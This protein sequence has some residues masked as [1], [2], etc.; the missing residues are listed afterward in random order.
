MGLLDLIRGTQKSAPEVYATATRATQSQELAG[1]VA[2]IAVAPSTVAENSFHW[3]SLTPDLDRHCWPYSVAM[4]TGEID[5]FVKRRQVFLAK[6]LDE[7]TAD[8]L[9]NKLVVRDRDGD[10]RRVCFE[11]SHLKGFTY[12]RCNNWKHAGIAKTSDGAF[13]HKGF[14][15]LLQRCDGFSR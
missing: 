15:T 13:V 5:Q 4:N 6:G 10:D 3:G 11:C 9:A 14:G 1:A 12:L 2:K 8:E 7:V